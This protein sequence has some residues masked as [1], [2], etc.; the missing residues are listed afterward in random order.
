[1]TERLTPE[2]LENVRQEREGYFDEEADE[3]RHRTVAVLD[4][5]Q[6]E[7]TRA[8]L[9]TLEA[10]L[11]AERILN[12][13]NRR[14]IERHTAGG[15]MTTAETLVK[16]TNRICELA[17][18]LERER[19]RPDRFPLSALW[20]AYERGARDARNA[21]ED[22]RVPRDALIRVSADAYVK[23]VVSQREEP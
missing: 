10:D 6:W 5:E 23:L 4:W 11:E 22:G 18:E 21:C 14:E 15:I 1:M 9:E 20:D 16:L 13:S 17:S 8:R 12:D 7:A 3:Y 19:N 2:R